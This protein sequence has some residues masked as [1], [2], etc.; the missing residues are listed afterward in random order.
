MTVSPGVWEVRRE[1]MEAQ[2]C[3]EAVGMIA[4]RSLAAVRIGDNNRRIYISLD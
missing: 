4:I 3:A 2:K 1:R